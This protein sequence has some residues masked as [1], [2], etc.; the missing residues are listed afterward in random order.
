VPGREPVRLP[1]SSPALKILQN[2]RDEAHRFAITYH[3]KL[4][5]RKTTRSE[6]DDIGITVKVKKLLL[7]HFKSIDDIRDA[8]VEELTG[9]Q[10]IGSKT[11]EKIHRFFH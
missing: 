2:I 7:G 4:R 5:D 6:L 10:G 1:L 3:R 11:A 8:T 9:I